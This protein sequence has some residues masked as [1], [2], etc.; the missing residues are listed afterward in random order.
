MPIRLLLLKVFGVLCGLDQTVVGILLASVL[1]NELGRDIQQNLVS[2]E[3]T[4]YQT[5][6]ACQVIVV[7]YVCL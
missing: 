2:G 3:V 7:C 4:P 6:W 1:P 5:K